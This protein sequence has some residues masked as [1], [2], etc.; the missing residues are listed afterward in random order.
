[1]AVAPPPRLHTHDAES[2]HGQEDAAIA[3]IF[4][5]DRTL[6]PRH[7]PRPDMASL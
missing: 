6:E 3:P 1:M 2:A 7:R 5:L 4:G